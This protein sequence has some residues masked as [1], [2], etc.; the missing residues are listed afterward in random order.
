[1]DYIFGCRLAEIRDTP[2]VV[3]SFNYYLFRRIAQELV[4]P[5]TYGLKVWIVFQFARCLD[6]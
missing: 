6:L 4:W 1:M 2:I 3:I 5:G